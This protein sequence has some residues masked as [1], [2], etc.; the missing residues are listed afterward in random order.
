MEALKLIPQVFF[1]LLARL[2]PGCLGLVSYLILWK[3]D[4][5]SII[6][7]LFGQSFARESKTISFFIFL[8]AGFV[9]GELLSPLAKM[10]QR[11]NEI[12]IPASTSGFKILKR[13]CRNYFKISFNKMFRVRVRKISLLK[14]LAKQKSQKQQKETKFDE[15]KLR[16]DR[17]RMEKPDIGAL[18]AKIRAEFT[19]HNGLSVVFA[20]DSICYPLSNLPFHCYILLL[21]LF[22]F[23]LAA[24]R[25]R[26]TDKTF[27]DTVA[28]FVQLLNE[29]NQVKPYVRARI[30]DARRTETTFLPLDDK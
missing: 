26:T 18:C 16:Y 12:K 29:Q 6:T 19:M 1:D 14:R 24:Y 21:L 8:G 27:N 20:I 30:E 5:E 25:G 3:K 13:R 9:L 28:K 11:I 22:I 15:K 2:V 10:V 4:W 7:Y 23:F 17:L